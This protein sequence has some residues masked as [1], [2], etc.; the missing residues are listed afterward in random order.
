MRLLVI[1]LQCNFVF[2]KND[3]IID[4]CKETREKADEL[5]QSVYAKAVS[6][7]EEFG[8]EEKWSESFGQQ[9]NLNNIPLETAEEYC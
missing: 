1:K 2:K 7:P 5:F 9:I 8:I 3:E 6:L 4:I